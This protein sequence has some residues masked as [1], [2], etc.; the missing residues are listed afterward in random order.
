MARG[1]DRPLELR[2]QH[3]EHRVLEGTGEMGTVAFEIVAGAHGPQHRGLET[4]E[5]ELESLVPHRTR[6][7]EARR[8]T[9]GREP[10]DRRAAR[11]R[12]AQERRD[13][14]E[15]LAG[16]IVAGCAQQAV[17]P[18]GGNVE[19]QGVTSR[20]EQ[21]D[22]WR[23]QVRVLHER[24]EEVSFHV[25]HADQLA[26][27]GVGQRLGEYHADQERPHEPRSLG[28]GDGV[29]GAPADASLGECAVHHGR[30]RRQMGPARE[31]RDH[32]PEHPVHVLR[33]DYEPG[34]LGT[35]ALAHQHGGRGLVARRLDPED[36][37]SH[38]RSCV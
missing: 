20:H 33:Q 38:G 35:A 13:L 8:I 23:C 6:K 22:E 30:Q 7:R 34:Q 29:H 2:D 3:V 17:A 5:G 36:D 19:Q 27:A 28:H 26:V 32:A 16:R 37:V 14:V 31:L 4:G 24:G 12:E 18:P 10:L 11:I 25:M 21:R 15:R 9:L 1:A